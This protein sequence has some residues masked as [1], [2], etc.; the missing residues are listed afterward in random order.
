MRAIRDEAYA[1]SVDLAAEK[2][3]FS[4]FER[5]AYLAGE[6]VSQLPAAL[7]DR[8]AADGIRNSHLTAIAPTGTISLLANNVTSGLEPLF[9]SVYRRRVLEVD[10]GYRSFEV[11]DFAYALWRRLHPAGEALPAQFVDAR[12]LDP[13]VHLDVQAA[14][15]PYVDS[16]ISKTVN[17]PESFDFERFR[18]LYDCAYDHGLKGCTTFR[19]NPVTGSILE[20]QARAAERAPLCCNVDREAD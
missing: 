2:G 1:T 14:L 7:R 3:A 20:V 4:R 15:Q 12:E 18:S 16:A 10:G 17:V 9:D 13:S 5:D 6:F 11:E 19:P 8:I